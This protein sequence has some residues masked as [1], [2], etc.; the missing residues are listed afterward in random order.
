MGRRRTQAD[1]HARPYDVELGL[2]PRPA[3]GDLRRVRFLVDAALAASLPLEMLDDVRHVDLAAV[4][5]SVLEGLVQELAGRADERLA[6]QVLL[7]A[8]LLADEHHLGLAR[9]LTEDG[10]GGG[11]VEVAGG[12]AGR[13]RAQRGQRRVRRDERRPGLVE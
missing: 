12:A 1:E 5:P 11:L 8:R 4:D 7:V 3:G 10:L 2:E 6:R 13:R 9:A